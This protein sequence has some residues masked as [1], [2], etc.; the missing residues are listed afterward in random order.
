MGI[1]DIILGL[2]LIYGLYKGIKNG[3]LVELAS[4]IAVIA[5]LYGAIHFS[6][7]VGEYL[8]KNMEWDEQYM[9]TIAFALTFILIVILVVVIGK[10]LTKII[11]FAMLG[12]LNK[13]AGA[14]FG[15][16]KVAVILGAF[17]V[18]FDKGN[19]QLG[20]IKPDYMEESK[21]YAPVK[22]IGDFVFSSVL[23]ETQFL[24]GDE[25]EQEGSFL[26]F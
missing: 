4:L 25:K 15:T 21:L 17:L 19:S 7:I 26:D 13:L 11:D 12:L 6:Y 16:L 23:K 1:L 9:N 2:L 20:V 8:S 24:D 5:G 3:L 18:F 10:I 22:E 14:V